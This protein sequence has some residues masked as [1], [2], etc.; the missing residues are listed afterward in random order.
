M[1]QAKQRGTFEERRKLALDRAAAEA[2]RKAEA[3]L[4][5]VER[6]RAFEATLPEHE[7]ALIREHRLRAQARIAQLMGL[8]LMMTKGK[9][10][11]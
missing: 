7:Q 2:L 10:S 9:E 6:Q 4:E 5:R 1:G 8:P 11:L 3:E